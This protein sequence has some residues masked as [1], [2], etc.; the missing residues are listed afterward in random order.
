[1]SIPSTFAAT[2]NSR[3]CHFIVASVPELGAVLGSFARDVLKLNQH[4]IT[5]MHKI[6][7]DRTVSDLM[8]ILFTRCSVPF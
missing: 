4:E 2:S 7:N 6:A 5:R 1:M 8:A 3:G